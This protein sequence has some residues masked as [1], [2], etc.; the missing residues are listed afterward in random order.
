MKAG[1]KPIAVFILPE[2]C[3]KENFYVPQ[4]ALHIQFLSKYA[5]NA[6]AEA[7]VAN[8]RREAELYQKYRYYYGYAFFIAQKI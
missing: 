5:G 1:Y 7:F 4:K 3:W 6:T 2:H 8:E